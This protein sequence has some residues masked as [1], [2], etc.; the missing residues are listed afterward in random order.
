MLVSI[1]AEEWPFLL[2]FVVFLSLH[3]FIHVLVVC[4]IFILVDYY[5]NP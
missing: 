2:A 3:D 4:V 5:S 1:R